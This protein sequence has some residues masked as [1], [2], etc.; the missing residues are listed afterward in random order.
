MVSSDGSGSLIAANI[1]KSLENSLNSLKIAK[2]SNF[3]L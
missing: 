3:V 1:G 2:V